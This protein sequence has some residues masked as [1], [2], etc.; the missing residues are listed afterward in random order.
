LRVT[1]SSTSTTLTSANAQLTLINEDSS[2]NN[3]FVALDFASLDSAPQAVV[4]ARIAARLNEHDDQGTLG[5]LAFFTK[6][7]GALTEVMRLTSAGRVGI[8]TTG[9]AAALDVVGS[10]I[11][12]GTVTT[13][14][15]LLTG[16][17]S[18]TITVQPQA[19]AGTYNFN[20]P[21]SA[22][23]SGQPLLSGGG[24]A[25]AMTFGTL[26][27]AAGGTGLTA[28]TS[29]GVL[30]Y[31]AAGTLASSGLLTTSAIL[32][33]GGAGATPTALGS[34]GTTTTVLHGNA[35][36]A[37]TFGAVALA[38]I[39]T[40]AASTI[41]GNNT[42]GASVPIALTTTQTKALLP[43]TMLAKSATYTVTTTDFENWSDIVCD[44][45]GGA[46]SLNL[47]S[48]S[49]LAG[50]RITVKDKNGSFNANN[51]TLVRAGS[52]KIE[53]VAASRVL[54]ADFGSYVVGTD[55]TDWYL[56]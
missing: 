8:G 46:F 15:A 54:S 38:D 2:V 40:I 17:T 41:L 33:G 5:D 30:G 23:A 55:G 10:G 27:V 29:G 48:P 12:S 56:F 37:P 51:V 26:G 21:T 28:G 25:A 22:G 52:E 3:N 4:F 49:T 50:L 31:T 16:A 36:G 20:L 44:S 13:D 7:S 32:L 14:A 47:P 1:R 6:A 39:A 53:N 9:P 34:L 45:S 43:R 24:G 35:A 11:F 19:V 18:G 42:G